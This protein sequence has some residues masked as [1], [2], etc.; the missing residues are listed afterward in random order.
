MGFGETSP[1]E[2]GACGISGFQEINGMFD[3]PL[4]QAIGFVNGGNHRFDLIF[5]SAVILGNA[6]FGMVG[7]LPVIIQIQ[8]DMFKSIV[9]PGG[10][11]MHLTHAAGLITI[12]CEQV[13]ERFLLMAHG[14]FVPI[15][16]Y[17]AGGIS[18]LSSHDGGPG[19]H[20]DGAIRITAGKG[21]SLIGQPVEMWSKNTIISQSG[22]GVKPLLI[23]GDQ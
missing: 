10:L 12:L 2:K 8:I 20:A 15:I 16:S 3:R 21:S 22:N 4:S 18:P 14:Q 5:P 9:R 7:H 19:G 17:T 1:Q 23:C 6:Q 13:G 11:E